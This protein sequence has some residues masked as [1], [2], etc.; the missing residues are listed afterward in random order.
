[1]ATEA[2]GIVEGGGRGE[3][4]GIA[5][6]GPGVGVGGAGGEGRGGGKRSPAK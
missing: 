5:G 2:A 1:M 4:G 6:P 3:L